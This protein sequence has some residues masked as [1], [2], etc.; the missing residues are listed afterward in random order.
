MFHRASSQCVYRYFFSKSSKFREFH[1]LQYLVHERPRVI[2]VSKLLKEGNEWLASEARTP[3][4]AASPPGQ[5]AA[6]A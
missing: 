1:E 5:A 3:G 6:E 4:C 2:G